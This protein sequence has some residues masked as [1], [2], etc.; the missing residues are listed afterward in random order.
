MAS[1][2]D[3]ALHRL[4]ERGH[5]KAWFYQGAEFPTELSFFTEL[6]GEILPCASDELLLEASEH[7]ALGMEAGQGEDE[8]VQLKARM[9]SVLAEVKVR[10]PFDRGNNHWLL[11]EDIS[12]IL[13]ALRQ[14][15]KRL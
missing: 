6:F 3:I 14:V 13:A 11:C 7:P 8:E 9:S 12:S 15:R 2:L 5:W 1:T 4:Q 10:A